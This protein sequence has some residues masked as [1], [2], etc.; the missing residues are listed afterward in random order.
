VVCHDPSF[1]D[2]SARKTFA[3][4]HP[5]WQVSA[6]QAPGPLVAEVVERHGR[7]DVLVSNDVHPAVR[8]RVEEAD[9]DDLRATLEA[10][11][12]APFAMVAAVVPV[13]KPQGSGKIVIVSSGTPLRGLANYGMYCAA[14]GGANALAVSLARELARHNIQVNA[15][16]PNFVE[17]PTYFPASLLAE[18]KNRVKILSQ[19]PMGRLGRPEEAGSLV[20]FLAGSGSDFITGRVI[21]LDG[22]WA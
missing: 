13:M 8:A 1:E 3:A 7:V 6:E 11:V 19:V 5:D 20:A 21:P 12:V 22:G 10:L 2:A 15:I 18:E 14:R 17:N 4:T 16:A 9:L